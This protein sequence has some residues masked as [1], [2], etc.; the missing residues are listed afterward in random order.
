MSSKL[1]FQLLVMANRWFGALEW[2]TP[3]RIPIPFIGKISGIQWANKIYH[4]LSICEYEK[5][6]WFK[7]LWCFFWGA[8]RLTFNTIMESMPNTKNPVLHCCTVFQNSETQ[9]LEKCQG[10]SLPPSHHPTNLC[11]LSFRGYLQT[12]WIIPA[13]W[14]G[15]FFHPKNSRLLG[16]SWVFPNEQ[17]H[18]TN[19]TAKLWRRSLQGWFHE[20]FNGKRM[21]I[22]LFGLVKKGTNRYLFDKKNSLVLGWRWAK[23]NIF[24]YKRGRFIIQPCLHKNKLCTSIFCKFAQHELEQHNF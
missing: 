11:H 10:H 17:T 15:I 6:Q 12:R 2:G 24:R 21:N 23:T 9:H 13:V 4:W 14:S 7:Q 3:L 16:D 1:L 19:L 5:L 8:C 20:F 22:W 18:N